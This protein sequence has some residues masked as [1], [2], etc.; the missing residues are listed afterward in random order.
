MRSPPV[1]PCEGLCG[2]LWGGAESLCPSRRI[3]A[4]FGPLSRRLG[5]MPIQG[6]ALRGTK[7]KAGKT[8]SPHLPAV[9]TAA[10]VR[11]R[12]LTGETVLPTFGWGKQS[13]WLAVGSQT[14]FA[15]WRPHP[16]W[17]ARGPKGRE[18]NRAL[19][20]HRLCGLLDFDIS[21]TKKK[22]FFSA[23]ELPTIPPLFALVSRCVGR[24]GPGW[25]PYPCRLSFGVSGSLCESVRILSLGMPSGSY[26]C[27]DNSSRNPWLSRKCSGM[28]C[29]PAAPYQNFYVREEAETWRPE[30]ETGS[31]PSG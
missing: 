7:R 27:S 4:G 29:F 8:K 23:I 16:L 20:G 28:V 13:V 6:T 12:Q 31:S 17:T 10:R 25:H 18:R 15:G 9:R 14:R 11:Q 26:E 3:Q 30:Q 19:P 22:L 5:G 2:L 24:M 1:W 21:L